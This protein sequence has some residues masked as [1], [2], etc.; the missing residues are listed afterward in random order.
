MSKQSHGPPLCLPY[1]DGLLASKPEGIDRV[2]RIL[3]SPRKAVLYHLFSGVGKAGQV[4]YHLSNV[5]WQGFWALY[6][7]TIAFPNVVRTSWGKRRTESSGDGIRRW[8]RWRF[9]A[10]VPLERGT[11]IYPNLQ[12]TVPFTL[13]CF[14]SFTWPVFN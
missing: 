13:L 11:L 1:H 10:Q 8:R 14:P 4:T 12:S 9:K 2:L 6:I 7:T 3:N 5:P